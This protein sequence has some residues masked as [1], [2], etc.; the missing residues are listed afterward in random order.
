[1]TEDFNLKVTVRNARLLRAVREAYGSPAE[2]CR[3]AGLSPNTVSALMT[4]RESPFKQDGSLTKTAEGIVSAL[5]IPADD[6]WPQH[7]ARLKAKKASVEI[8]MDAE[9]FQAIAQDDPEKRAIYRNAVEKWSRDLN[10]REK[11]VL[12]TR[13]EGGTYEDAAKEIGGVTRER[14]RQVELRAYRKMRQNARRSGVESWEDM[15]S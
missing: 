2:M 11:A 3:A 9:T 1:M 15:A 14:A 12:L 13:L 8:E 7:I 6:L 10:E 5:G 4:M